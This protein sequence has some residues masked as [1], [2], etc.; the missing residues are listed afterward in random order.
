[1]GP[2]SET[3]GEPWCVKPLR[4]TAVGL[5]MGSGDGDLCSDSATGVDPAASFC[6]SDST[7]IGGVVPSTAG[8]ASVED[9]L[10]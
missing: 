6:S 5:L 2:R 10:T 8:S 1:M 3:L 9:D 7:L 4:R